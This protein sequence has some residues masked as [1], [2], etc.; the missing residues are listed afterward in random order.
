MVEESTKQDLDPPV[1]PGGKP[2]WQPGGEK[3]GNGVNLGL[4]RDV[5][6]SALHHGDV[7][8]GVGDVGEDGEQS[9][10]VQKGTPIITG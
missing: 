4:G 9:S 6:G 2:D 7:A 3:A 10:L 5:G 8:G 1:K